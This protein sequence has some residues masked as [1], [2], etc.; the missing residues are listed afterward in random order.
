MA[1]IGFLLW[2]KRSP[3]SKRL[4]FTCSSPSTGINEF[5][6]LQS[7]IEK[8]NS[9]FNAS[10]PF[11]EASVHSLQNLHPFK[12]RV[13]NPD[14]DQ[15]RRN[16]ID[17]ILESS[18]TESNPFSSPPKL[19]KAW[20]D[21]SAQA[22]GYTHS[23]TGSGGISTIASR[24]RSGSLKSGSEKRRSDSSK[25]SPKYLASDSSEEEFERVGKHKSIST[26]S[27]ATLDDYGG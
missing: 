1:T 14:L 7:A 16:S 26:S 18:P 4:S 25:L 13:V 22:S 24:R 5:Q 20:P 10:R 11:D 19:N 23:R 27:S 8:S 17:S 12:F 9:P 3:S 21:N 15:D 6:G 2:K